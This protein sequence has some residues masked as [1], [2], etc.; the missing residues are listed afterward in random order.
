MATT[1]TNVASRRAPATRTSPA[2]SSETASSSTTRSTAP[3]SRPSCSCRR[4]RS[5]TR[6]TGRCRSRTSRATVASSRSTD[7]ATAVRPAA[8]RCGLRRARVR[9]RCTG[10]AGRDRNGTRGD[11]RLLARRPA[12]TAAG[13]RAPRACRRSG[14]H[15]ACVRQG[16]RRCRSE[17]SSPIRREYDTYE[18]WAKY[19][20][21]YWL[22]D[23]RDFV[24]FFISKM[25]T[26]PHSTKPIE[27][28]VG[29]ALET[30]G[31]TLIAT[32]EGPGLEPEEAA[33]SAAASAALCSSSTAT[34]DAIRPQRAEPRWPSK[35]EATLVML[36]GSGHAPHARDPVKVNLLLR[37]FVDVAAGSRRTAW[38][39]GRSRRKRALYISS[40]IGLGHAQRDVAIARELRKLHPDLEIDWLAQDPVTSGARSAGRAHPSRPAQHL[41][42]ESRHIESE[43]AEHD[44]HCFQASGGWTRSCSPTSWSFTTSCASE[45]YDIWIGDEAWEL[46]YYLHENPE[47][48]RAAYV[49]SPGMISP[50]TT[51]Q[52]SPTLSRSTPPRGWCH[53]RA[54]PERASRNGSCAACRPGPCRAPRR[55]LRRS[56]RTAP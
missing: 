52:R 39:R 36:E 49:G 34:R 18:G 29:W 28:T 6:G 53:R 23:Y 54:T 19:N 5:S 50:A 15:R 38:T 27:D 41:A 13:R 47:E 30:D 42:N 16:R 48:K 45:Q 33:P 9:G 1:L 46:D 4:G 35:R 3:A 32:Q 17:P 22:R 26:E 56:W 7:A 55:P 20:R 44:L 43:S 11:R 8:G 2:T 31:E 37:D 25:F 24:E 10:R 40:P 51:S 12:R 21:H 14:L